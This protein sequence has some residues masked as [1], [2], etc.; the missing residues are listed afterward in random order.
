M[1]IADDIRPAHYDA[2]EGK[3]Q[4]W[5]EAWD[6]YREAFFV[7]NIEKYVRRYRKKDGVKDLLKARTYLNK[8][9]EKE[10]EEA[11]QV[12]GRNVLER[13]QKTVV[14]TETQAVVVDGLVRDQKVT[15]VEEFQADTI[16]VTGVMNLGTSGRKDA[17]CLEDAN[18]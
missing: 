14:P 2:G 18:R 1:S 7:L 11:A 12:R 13:W 5:D 4:F 10:E 6:R 3:P 17:G 15:L 9:I 16:K 8:L